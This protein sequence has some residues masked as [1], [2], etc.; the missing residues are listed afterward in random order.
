MVL[1]WIPKLSSYPYPTFLTAPIYTTMDRSRLLA[2]VQLPVSS[3]EE[4][5]QWLLNGTA[6]FVAS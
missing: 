3:D 5:M 4:G 1:A 2:E 6:M